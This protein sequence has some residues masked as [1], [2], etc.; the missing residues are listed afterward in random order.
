MNSMILKAKDQR[1]NPERSSRLHVPIALFEISN[2]GT[3]I[4]IIEE[5]QLTKDSR[6]VPSAIGL[7]ASRTATIVTQ[8]KEPSLTTIL[9][10]VIIDLDSWKL[11]LHL[12]HPHSSGN[13]DFRLTPGV[14]KRCFKCTGRL[15][16]RSLQPSV[17]IWQSPVPMTIHFAHDETTHDLRAED[18]SKAHRRCRLESGSRRSHICLESRD[19]GDDHATRRSAPAREQIWT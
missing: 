8:V 4:T 14:E 7:D 2:A 17:L 9:T 18:E 11:L 5:I 19:S 16:A 6:L 12:L 15:A 1:S 10:L 13:G 3:I